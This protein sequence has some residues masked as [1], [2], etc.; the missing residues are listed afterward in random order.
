VFKAMI[1]V[2]G[3]AVGTWLKG[4]TPAA[5]RVRPEL[6]EELPPTAAAAVEKAAARIEAY[7]RG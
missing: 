6:F 7:W 4:G 1:M 5:P 2:G 3:R